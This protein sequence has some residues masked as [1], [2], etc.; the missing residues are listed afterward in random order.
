MADVGS[1]AICHAIGRDNAQVGFT[2][3][4]DWCQVIQV[5]IYLP[6]VALGASGVSPEVSAAWLHVFIYAVV[7]AYEWFVV[8]VALDVSPFATAGFVTPDLILGILITG[9]ADGL[10]R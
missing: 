4:F 9:I 1:R 6:A 5:V 10:M 8:R 2:V 7:L 3:A